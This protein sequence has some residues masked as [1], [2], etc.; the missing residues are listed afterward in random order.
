MV[1]GHAILV[2]AASRSGGPFSYTDCVHGDDDTLP[3]SLDALPR[4][5]AGST[6]CSG[7]K[8]LEARPGALLKPRGSDISALRPSSRGG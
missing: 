2:I 8:H 4:S 5:A 3:G 6:G 7:Q 1:L